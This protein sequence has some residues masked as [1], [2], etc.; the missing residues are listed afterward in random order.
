[1]QI[2]FMNKY[3][4]ILI[5]ILSIFTRAEAIETTIKGFIP[6][7]EN[8]EIR[9]MTYS[10][11]ITYT[12]EILER[13]IIDMNGYFFLTF[14]L[15]ETIVSYLDIE[16]YSSGL[17][18]EPG[19]TYE[20]VCDSVSITNQYRPFYQKQELAIEIIVEPEP[21]L[22]KL[23]SEF[24]SS[25]NNFILENFDAVYKKRKRSLITSYEKEIKQKYSTVENEYFQNYITY[26]IASVDLAASSTKKPEL[27]KK[28]FYKKRV[29]YNNT[30]Y[31][32]FFNQYFEQFLTAQTKSISRADLNAAINYQKS[33]T[34]LTDTLGKDTLL[35]H[36]VIRELVLLKGLKELYYNPDYWQPY[37]IDILKQVSESSKFPEHRLI[38]RNI[39]KSLTKLKKG[40]TSPEFKLLSLQ[41]DSV[42]LSDLYD[43]PVYLSFITTWSYG[44][45]AE[46]KLMTDL[47]S[48]YKGQ[49]N[50]ITVFLDNNIDIVKKYVKEKGYEWTFLYNGNDYDLLKDYDIKTFPLFVLINNKGEI[51]QYPAYKPSEIIESSFKSLIDRK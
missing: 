51:F 10:D 3:N 16:F 13:E 43:K 42:S 12:K 9:L 11:Q 50:F 33:Y 8:L 45:L 22:N 48:R 29:L 6:G 32:N 44:C 14:D 27:F 21:G 17:F 19:G 46:M 1:M 4:F 24:N 35:R 47:Y 39:I 7:A 2:F 38:A 26:K 5:L 34:A 40:T 25:F 36:E 28:Y 23:I 20:I 41:G 30:E 49:I 15:K 37:I 31:M 18:I